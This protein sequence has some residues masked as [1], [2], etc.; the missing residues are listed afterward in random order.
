MEFN[1]IPFG[2]DILENKVKQGFKEVAFA[3]GPWVFSKDDYLIRERILGMLVFYHP[4]GSIFTYEYI[5]KD[6]IT[7]Q[8]SHLEPVEREYNDESIFLEKIKIY[9]LIIGKKVI[10]K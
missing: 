7:G 1:L 9:K 4:N 8:T 6:L 10:L 2:K 3:F 5:K